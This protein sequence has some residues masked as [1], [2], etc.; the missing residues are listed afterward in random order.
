L[1]SAVPVGQDYLRVTPDRVLA[2]VGSEVILKA[3]VCTAGGYLLANQRVEWL[4]S[5]GGTGQFV[6]LGHRDQ[7]TVMR[8][9]L[10]TPR[11][12]DNAYAIT[13]TSWFPM[14]LQRGTPDP[15]D[16]VQILK[17]DAWISVTSATE[18]TSHVTAYAPGISDWNLRRAT[19]VI[20]W[21][22]A[23]WILPPS[24]VV[25]SGRPHVL[26]TTVA[27]RTDGVPLVGWLVRYEVPTGASLGYEGGSVVEVPTDAN[28][29]ASVEVTPSGLAGGSA[30]VNV[31]IIR[32][33]Q[34]GADPSPRLEVGRGATTITWASGVAPQPVPP[35]AVSPP[36]APFT[37]S[38]PT[39]VTPAP[40]EPTPQPTLPATPI[41]SEPYTPPRDEPP[42]A[43]TRPRLE[44]RLQNAGPDQ[45]A[46]GEFVRFDV[47]VTNVGDATARGI[48]IRDQFDRGLSHE[49]AQPNQFAVEYAGMRDLAPGASERIP[50]TFGVTA[51]GTHCHTVTVSADGAEPVSQRGCIT[52]RQATLEVTVTG[53]RTH[54]LGEVATFRAVVRNTGD[55]AAT[56]IVI[57]AR[58][59]PALLPREAERGHERLP[60]GSIQLQIARMEPAERR[61]FTVT[62]E[63][64][65]QS[66]SACATFIATAD[67][68][69]RVADEACIEILPPPPGVAAGA[70]SPALPNLRVTVTESANPVRSGEK[71]TIFI[72][73]VNA[74]QQPVRQVAVRVLLPPEFTPDPTQMQP[75]GAIEGQEI[76]FAAVAEIQ[77]Q[78]QRRY[79]I[80]VTAGQAGEVQVFAAVAVSGLTELIRADSNL[81]RILPQ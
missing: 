37:P 54:I 70:A 38:P 8:W 59:D 36:P 73:V 69:I 40:Y 63:C 43:T 23:Q 22:D 10:D 39:G 45:V 75:Q 31:T 61:T 44:V 7:V 46:V 24:A 33:P 77:P 11:K 30:T 3:G 42:A 4:L 27:R 17:G 32:P 15:S 57:I 35:S 65:T 2:P 25:E 71:P 12:I 34:V 49:R 80:P 51:D 19:A 50:L 14:C 74:G 18:G 1:G 21:V 81:I 58:C 78:Q 68:G 9:M 79:E 26:T 53:P 72:N 5:P 52:A 48:L 20:Y 60:D 76:T 29:R 66:T 28:G 47:T 16:D 64:R 13:A 55:V 56:N 41:P 62:A 67:G 6:D